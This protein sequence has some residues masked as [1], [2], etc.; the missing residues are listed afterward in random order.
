VVDWL[1]SYL[2]TVVTRGD[3]KSSA[4]TPLLWLNLLVTVPCVVTSFRVTTDFRWALFGLA[5]LIVVYTLVAYAMLVKKDPRLV[6]S[7]TFQREMRALDI[8]AERG[9]PV[10]INPVDLLV[11]EN[12]TRGL[13]P[14]PRHIDIEVEK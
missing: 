8:V 14:G 5:G 1:K 11:T 3:H 13:P 9:G 12:P 6:Q 7:E 10:A 2:A 4:L